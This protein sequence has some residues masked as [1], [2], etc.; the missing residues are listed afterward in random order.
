MKDI[1]IIEFC[2]NGKTVQMK[3]AP[4]RTLLSVLRD[5]LKLTGTKEGCNTGD[6]GACTVLMDGEPINACLMPYVRVAG[7]DIL[8]IEGL[9][10]AEKLT[11]LQQSFIDKG[12]FQCGYCSP[13]MIL[14]LHAFLKKNQRPTR[15]QIS[16]AIVGNLCRCGCYV[17][18]VEAVE[19]LYLEKGK[20]D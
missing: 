10:N 11:A 1:V 16:E 17:Q 3:S 18:I 6:C 9:G 12:A 14:T 7:H 15:E 8:T 5:D 20:E 4:G 2:L 13:G 19:A